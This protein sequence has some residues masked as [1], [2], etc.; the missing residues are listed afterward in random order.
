M[1]IFIPR[2][3]YAKC[4][5]V[6]NHEP[7][8]LSFLFC[9]SVFTGH[10]R[11]CAQPPTNAKIYVVRY[12]KYAII[13]Y[14]HNTENNDTIFLSLNSICSAFLLLTAQMVNQSQEDPKPRP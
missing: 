4:V 10:D 1:Q 12:F 13:K 8:F 5:D 14:F 6:T 3:A 2:N 11:R 7:Q 9:K